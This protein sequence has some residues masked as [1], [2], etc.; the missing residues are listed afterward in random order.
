MVGRG[1]VANPGASRWGNSS[2]K[3]HMGHQLDRQ[4][5]PSNS[6]HKEASEGGQAWGQMRGCPEGLVT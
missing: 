5:V 6:C 2:P 4:K 1:C 3:S